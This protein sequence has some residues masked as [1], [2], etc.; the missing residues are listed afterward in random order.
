MDVEVYPATDRRWKDLRA[1]FG[2]R[3]ATEGCWCM[4]WRR[5]RADY[6]RGR[7]R[8]NRD[9]LHA[10]CKGP[11]APGLLAYADGEPVGWCAVARR[12]EYA[13]LARARTLAPVDDEPDVWSVPC[14]FVH[15]SH[16]GAGVASALLA[17]AVE[18]A[19][20]HGARIVE[21]YPTD[22][23]DRTVENSFAHTGVISLFERHGFAIVARRGRRVVMRNYLADGRAGAVD[24]S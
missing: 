4:Y 16:R 6:E 19:R 23:T 15:R 8:G 18:H 14:F 11:T 1:L 22:T 24:R 17:A 2:E 13:R 9:A 21:G 3:G 7:G 5:E 20:E 12:D 10:L